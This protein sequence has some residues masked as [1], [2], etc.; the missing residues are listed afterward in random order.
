MSDPIRFSTYVLLGITVFGPLTMLLL[1]ACVQAAVSRGWL[2][3]TAS[4]TVARVGIQDLRFMASFVLVTGGLAL[5]AQAVLFRGRSLSF[6]LGLHPLE[7][8]SFTSLLMLVVDTNGFFWH[9]FSHQNRRAFRI[10]HGGHHRTGGRIHVGVGFH[11]NTVWDYPLH[12]GI[13]LSLVVSLLPLAT[14]KYPVVTIVYAVTV[15]VLGIAAM[16]SG[17]E[18][19]PPVKW[20]LRV[21][22]LPIRIVPTAIRLED[23]Q[24]HHAQGDCN[25][26][27]FFSHWDSLFGSWM[28]AKHAPRARPAADY[29][30]F[31]LA[32]RSAMRSS[33]EVHPA[34]K[35]RPGPS[36]STTSGA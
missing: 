36:R 2:Q 30:F 34:S 32:R 20:A 24:R 15:Y 5:A 11:S 23:H 21:V 17:L 9:R 4:G 13:S 33:A 27:V 3:R 19:T 8:L 22:L 35:A 16:H 7:M 18:E 31:C 28:P 6:D 25:Y 10:F 12:S 29:F 1:D 26:G 14:G